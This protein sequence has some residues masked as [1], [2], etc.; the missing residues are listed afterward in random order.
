MAIKTTITFKNNRV[1]VERAVLES[2]DRAT[3]RSAALLSRNVK[4]NTP[5]KEGHLK[6]S[7]AF[8]K[9]GIGSAEVYNASVEGGREINYAVHVEYGTRYMAPRAMFRKGAAQSE[10]PI[11]G[12]FKQELERVIE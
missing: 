1:P 9:T 2:I 12:I 5:V 4:V 8:R 7:I 3:E 6:R 11:Q 10:K